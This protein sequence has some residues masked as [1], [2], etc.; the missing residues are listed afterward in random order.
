MFLEFS[1]WRNGFICYLYEL[2][3]LSNNYDYIIKIVLSYI[4]NEMKLELEI[5]T[6]RN[7][8]E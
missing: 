1:D 8:I 6:I 5:N 2:L 3:L 4:K 7:L